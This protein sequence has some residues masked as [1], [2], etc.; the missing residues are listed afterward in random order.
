MFTWNYCDLS[1]FINFR[2]IYSLSNSSNNIVR[3]ITIMLVFILECN[4]VCTQEQMVFVFICQWNLWWALWLSL[5]CVLLSYCIVAFLLWQLSHTKI[6]YLN[7]T[8]LRV[9]WHFNED[10][11]LHWCGYK[12]KWNQEINSMYMNLVPTMFEHL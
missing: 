2:N 8:Q 12:M 4:A 7:M 6:R 1:W 11:I 3:F 5:L 10:G 9:L